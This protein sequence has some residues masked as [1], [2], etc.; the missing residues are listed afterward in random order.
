MKTFR[1]AAIAVCAFIVSNRSLAA[2]VVHFAHHTPPAAELAFGPLF[3]LGVFGH[4]GIFPDTNQYQVG[5]A[6]DGR[7]TVDLFRPFHPR[8]ARIFELPIVPTPPSDGELGW[9]RD[10]FE[11]SNGHGFRPGLNA[12]DWARFS[13]MESGKGIFGHGSLARLVQV[14]AE[15]ARTVNNLPLMATPLEVSPMR[16][17]GELDVPPLPL[18]MG[19]A[20]SAIVVADEPSRRLMPMGRTSALQQNTISPVPEPGALLL[21]LLGLL[22][23][24]LRRQAFR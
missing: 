4:P 21:T 3:D 12:T 8:P 15:G 18:A 9:T 11:D 6:L 13:G 24:G 10:A 7:L 19:L 5:V 17:P 2:P 1:L 20:D 22:A 14:P 16:L 23:L